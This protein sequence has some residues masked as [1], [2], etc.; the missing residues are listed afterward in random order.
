MAT[1]KKHTLE[2]V[3]RKLATADREPPP[4]TYTTWTAVA[5]DLVF[6]VLTYGPSPLYGPPL[7]RSYGQ[8]GR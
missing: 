8:F 3:V 4:R 2:Q 1:R 6:T 7:G 5:P